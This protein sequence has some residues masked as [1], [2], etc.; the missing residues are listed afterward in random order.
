MKRTYTIC[1]LVLTLIF[2]GAC[3]YLEYDES[4]YL[5][6][7][8]VFSDF[9]RTK[10]FLTGI[11][12]YLPDGF[13][14]VDGAM[15][16]S[17]SDDAIHV[18]KYSAIHKF[19][20]GSWSAV[21]PLDNV[22][23]TMYTGIRAVNK[24]L[25]ETEG[26]EFEDEKYN[27]DYPDQM[28]QFRLYPYEARFLRAF[29]YFE[30]AKRYGSVPLITDV[31]EPEEANTVSASSFDTIIQFVVDECD[32]VADTL[33]VTYLNLPNGE[34]GRATKGAAMALKTRALLYAASPLHNESDATEKWITAAEAAHE[35]IYM[36]YYSLEGNY[37]DLFNN[38]ES[39]ELI[40]GRRESESNRFERNNFPIGYEGGNT[41]TCPTQNLVDAYDMQESGLSIDEDGSGYDP[42]FPYLNRDP[43]MNATILAN[44]DSW[45][46]KTIETWYGGANATP[47]PNATLTGYYL[48]KYVIESINLTPT[49]T[50][51]K[52]HTWILFRYGEVLLNFAE[53]M[54][55]I[56]GPEDP[57]T[58]SMTAL[59]AVNSLRIRAGMPGYPSGMT[60]VEF[61]DKLRNERRVELAFEDHRFWDIRRWKIGEETTDIYG[62]LITENIFG[63]LAYTK[64]LI[65]ERLF[66]DRMN[67]YPIPENELFINSNLR[68]NTG[69]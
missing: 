4:S 35:V 62:I 61:R 37:G 12:A 65:E 69:W 46:G 51:Q 28:Q 64:T 49:N 5:L 30:L 19:N 40:L 60:K 32:L 38:H 9:D 44:G 26:Q 36:G 29:F 41:G 34:T 47:K 59:E 25:I 50:T 24:F 31:L 57:S 8:E 67:L 16:S 48:K 10:S 6:E 56:Y 39:A 43:R 45:K 54:N 68:Q 66:E 1:I 53:A 55:E 27:E 13:N 7:E 63:G 58:F 15:R 14:P 23:G 20:D 3:E 11:Y 42:N 17:A 52:N 2:L 18:W 22:Y 33:P 21:Q